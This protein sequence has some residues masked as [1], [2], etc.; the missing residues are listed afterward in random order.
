M[1]L[2]VSS[3]N[4]YIISSGKEGIVHIWDFKLCK[5]L[6]A[7]KEHQGAVNQVKTVITKLVNGEHQLL[8]SCGDDGII[9]VYNLD[10]ITN[11]N[12]NYS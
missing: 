1:D 12:E 6:H 4:R 5:K 7:C 10:R 9:N 3:C 8:Y 11:P 2:H